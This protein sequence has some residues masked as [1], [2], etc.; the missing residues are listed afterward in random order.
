[1]YRVHRSNAETLGQYGASRSHGGG[2]DALSCTIALIDRPARVRPYAA[3]QLTLAHRA[4]NFGERTSARSARWPD[5]RWHR[6]VSPL[7]SMSSWSPSTIHAPVCSATSTAIFRISASSDADVGAN[8]HHAFR[9][10]IRSPSTMIF[11]SRRVS[12][13]NFGLE[14]PSA[15]RAI[16][17]RSSCRLNIA[18]SPR[19]CPTIVRLPILLLSCSIFFFQFYFY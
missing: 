8:A 4:T 3:E 15:N 14:L 5:P 18:K 1:M 2:I 16:F 10:E 9:G 6:L 11:S 12:S 19:H 17:A 7:N 13:Q